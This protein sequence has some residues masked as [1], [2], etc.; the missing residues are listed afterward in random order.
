MN[1]RDLFK[2]AL[3]LAAPKPKP[4][5]RQVIDFRIPDK[6]RGVIT[7]LN[8]KQIIIHDYAEIGDDPEKRKQIMN[9][10]RPVYDRLNAN[11]I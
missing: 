7:H 9:I 5:P 8:S 6:F 3:A 10:L 2:I 4:E 11:R 1:R